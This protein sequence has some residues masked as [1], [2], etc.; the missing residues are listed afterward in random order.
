M[1]ISELKNLAKKTQLEISD[2]ESEFFLKGFIELKKPLNKFR[3]LKLA[4]FKP[5]ERIINEKLTLKDLLLTSRKYQNQQISR[6]ILEHNSLVSANNLIILPL[7][8]RR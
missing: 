2:R 3:Q 7:K 8:K 4:K 6:K 1:K 5:Q